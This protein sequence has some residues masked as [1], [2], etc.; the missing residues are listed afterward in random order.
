MKFFVQREKAAFEFWRAYIMAMQTFGPECAHT[1][2]LV[3]FWR[4]EYMGWRALCALT[5]LF[6]SSTPKD[7]TKC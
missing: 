2:E 4:K 5:E 3:R 6:D 1:S 7:S